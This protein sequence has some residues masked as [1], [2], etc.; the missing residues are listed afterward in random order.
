MLVLLLHQM[1]S[2][3]ATLTDL[4]PDHWYQVRVAAVN[5]YGSQ[6]WSLASAPFTTAISE[7]I[8]QVLI[9][10][11]ITTTASAGLSLISHK[12]PFYQCGSKASYA[13]AGIARAEM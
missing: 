4:R 7:S 2:T 6:G 1:T 12:R 8:I 10:A 9:T 11:T 5:V 13:S 3:T